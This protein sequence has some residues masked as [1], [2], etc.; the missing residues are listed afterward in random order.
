MSEEVKV[1]A[2]QA[3][4]PQDVMA[5]T[6]HNPDDPVVSAKTLLEAGCHFGHKVSRWN[7][8]MRKF[9]YGKR[10]NL[11][12]ID[13]NKSAVQMQSAYHA[14][15]D[16]VSKGGKVLFVGT[17][18][19]AQKAI[20]EE[21]VRSGSF[22]VCHRWLGGTLTNFHT[23]V[24]RIALLRSLEQEEL[25]GELE[26]L[27]KKEAAE[28]LKLKAKLSQN[29]EGIKELRLLPQALVV[30]DPKTEHNAVAEA[31]L[32][33]IPVFALGD[34]NTDPDTID[35]LIPANDDGE[36]SIRIIV[37]LLADAVVE[38]KG[39]EP[40]YAYK[41][42]EAAAQTMAEM[43]K[44]VDPNEQSKA[45]RAKLRD[46]ALAMRKNGKRIA[47]KKFVKKNFRRFSDEKK[48]EEK[49][50]AEAAKAEA[51]AEEK[52]ATEESK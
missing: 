50:A 20:Q 8:K 41:N 10:N 4:Q 44:G 2:V 31:K 49:P 12:I 5:S 9:I 11:H 39:G 21:A 34:T 36:A 35:Y 13:L 19:Y 43:L 29:L 16:I 52:P 51:P 28:K 17:K 42:S 6:V 18:A 23:I 1:E 27:P 45:I 24:K 33:N 48:E 22:F 30:V 32:L 47:R 3:E 40:L 25:S 7:P 26:K 46:D 14:L 38:G 15:K 37:G